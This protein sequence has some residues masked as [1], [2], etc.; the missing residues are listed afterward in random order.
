MREMTS[1]TLAITPQEE[2][3]ASRR[4][5]NPELDCRPDR[6]QDQLGLLLGARSSQRSWCL[7]RAV[8]TA[9]LSWY[10]FQRK[11][12]LDIPS[13]FVFRLLERGIVQRWSQQT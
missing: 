2:P 4:R 3:M 8:V 7:A 12:Q 9:G 13:V 5:V 10:I 6:P 1:L 11:N